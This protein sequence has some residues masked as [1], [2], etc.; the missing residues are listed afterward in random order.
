MDRNDIIIFYRFYLYDGK[1]VDLDFEPLTFRSHQDFVDAFDEAWTEYSNKDYDYD[2]VDWEYID[3][4]AAYGMYDN[5]DVWEAYNNLFNLS[6]EYR[7]DSEVML[8]LA[9]VYGVERLEEV[10]EDAYQG[11]YRDMVEYAYSLAE[12][13]ILGVDTYALYFDY[14]SFGHDLKYDFDLEMLVEEYDYD[15][16]E[17][18]DLLDGRDEEFA[19]WY[20]D[21]LGDVTDLGR[22]TLENYTDF[23]RL[24]RDLEYEGYE[25]YG[26]HIFRPY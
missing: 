15:I 1:S 22:N 12:E 16:S 7:I 8:Y 19:E 6:K 4:N 14:E 5:E 24:A 21:M 17:A 10:M 3:K 20:I 11:E 26:G 25:D 18:E 9:A 23:K 2:I 13:G